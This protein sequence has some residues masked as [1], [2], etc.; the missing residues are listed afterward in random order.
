MAGMKSSRT[1][2]PS[3]G[4]LLQLWVFGVCWPC[5]TVTVS[6]TPICVAVNRI[7][8]TY[9]SSFMSTNIITWSPLLCHVVICSCRSSSKFFQG[10]IRAPVAACP[11]I[12]C[13]EVV[14]CP[15]TLH[16]WYTAT[17]PRNGCLCL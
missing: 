3:M 14:R 1:K 2:I 11:Q 6:Q 9:T 12:C 8:S 13:W 5:C 4:V 15:F 10:H 7:G 16:G 17:I